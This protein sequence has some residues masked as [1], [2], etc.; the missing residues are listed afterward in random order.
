MHTERYE[1]ETLTIGKSTGRPTSVRTGTYS[2]G[3]IGNARYMDD[4]DRRRME[5][6]LRGLG[7]PEVETTL[8]VAGF[9]YFPV[10]AKGPVDRLELEYK[11]RGGKVTM[12][13]GR[14]R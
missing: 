1:G 10:K 11:P 3:S 4:E 14:P 9:L 13:L 6:E 2:G 8:P 5:E 12:D 7:L